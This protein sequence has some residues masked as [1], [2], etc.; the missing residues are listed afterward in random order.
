MEINV[1]S[2]SGQGNIIEPLAAVPLNDELQE[3]RASVAKAEA[4]VLLMVTKK[5]AGFNK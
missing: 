5:V 4:D 1:S 2:G 3:A